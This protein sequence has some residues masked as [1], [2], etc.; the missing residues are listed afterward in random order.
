[1]LQEYDPFDTGAA[2]ASFR[3]RYEDR[4]KSLPAFTSVLSWDAAQVAITALR[5][6]KK[7]E[8]LKEAILRIG[9]FRGLQQTVLIDANG[10]SRREAVFSVVRDGAFGKVE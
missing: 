5:Q 10:D 4:F 8:S 6:A 1:M 9:S 3:Q 2:Y 7:G